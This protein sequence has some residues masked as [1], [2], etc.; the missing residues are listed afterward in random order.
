MSDRVRAPVSAELAA[1]LPV[2]VLI[3]VVLPRFADACEPAHLTVLR[4]EGRS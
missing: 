4:T 2:M 1:E 3:I